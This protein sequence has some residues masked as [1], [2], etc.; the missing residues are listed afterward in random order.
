LNDTNNLGVIGFG[1]F[2]MFAVQQFLQIPGVKLTGM[3]GTHRD[4]AYRAAQR[5]GVEE[6][7]DPEEMVSRDNVDLVY[8]ATPPFLHYPQA[9]LA[10]NAGKHVIV[11]KPFALT[12]A[13]ADEMIVAAKKKNLLVVANLMQRYNPMYDR[14][15]ELIN[16]KALGDLLHCYF[17]NYASDEY[18]PPEHWFWDKEKS[19]GIFVEHGV[20]F[21]D[22]FEGWLGKGK[23]LSAAKSIRSN[24][25]LEDQVTCTIDYNGILVNIYHGFTHP[26]RMDRQ[27]M[28]FTFERGELTLTEWIPSRMRLFAISGEVDM[29]IICRIFPGARIDVMKLYS[30]NERLVTAHSK[31]FEVYQQY[32]MRFAEGRKYNIYSVAVRNLF[33]DQIAWIKDKSHIRKI[34]EENSRSSLETAL[35]ADRLAL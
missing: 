14:V 2:A 15:R 8:I 7:Q 16:S 29:N 35:E 28:N 20:H 31:T 27:E 4:A 9:M 17:E 11:E 13:Q 19:G 3:S 32:Q 33:A 5:F 10:L 25:L 34:T 24:P 30:G 23:V 26:S 21:F 18:L 6:I 1:S 12:L 22:M